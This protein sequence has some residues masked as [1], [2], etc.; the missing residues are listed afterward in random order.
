[1]RSSIK[2]MEAPQHFYSFVASQ[3]STKRDLCAVF[4]HLINTACVP[5]WRCKIFA[6]VQQKNNKTNDSNV[7]V[8]SPFSNT[9]TFTHN[10]PKLI[11]VAITLMCLLG[12]GS[13]TSEHQ[14]AGIFPPTSLRLL[15]LPFVQSVD[16]TI[17]RHL[18]VYQL[19]CSLK[20][21]FSN[22]HCNGAR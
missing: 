5:L 4:F 7:S 13:K 2:H 6:I 22:R 11:L 20:C 8:H 21:C 12:F 3:Q 17:P 9:H 1:M 18:K 16:E 19:K 15:R 10:I 14:A